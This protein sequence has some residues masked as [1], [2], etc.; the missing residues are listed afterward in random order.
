M[1]KKKP[2][3]S[4]GKTQQVSYEEV[5]MALDSDTGSEKLSKTMSKKKRSAKVGSG[6]NSEEEKDWLELR[7][8][9]VLQSE[10]EAIEGSDKKKTINKSQKKRG[11]GELDSVEDIQTEDFEEILEKEDWLI[12]GNRKILQDSG[13]DEIEPEKV[14]KSSKKAKAVTSS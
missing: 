3:K 8:R 12:L 11:R 13:S 14:L 4:R 6:S 10:T 5:D 7:S 2:R 9:K 1:G